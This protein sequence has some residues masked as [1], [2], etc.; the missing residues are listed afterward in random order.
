M[1]PIQRYI[2]VLLIAATAAVGFYVFQPSQAAEAQQA[3]PDPKI[4]TYTLPQDVKWV[5]GEANDR[6][7]LPSDPGATVELIRWHEGNMSR[8][9]THDTTRYI[10]VLEGTWWMGWGPNY[11]PDSTFPVKAGTSVVHHA[12]QLHYDGA[13][14]GEGDA[15]LLIIS[16]DNK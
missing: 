5:K 6:A 15:L 12:G 10:Q 16:V 4:I 7:T 14:K 9:H 2:P 8:P 3:K 1:S 13:K 11:D